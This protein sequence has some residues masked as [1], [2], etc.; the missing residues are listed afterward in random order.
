MRDCTFKLAGQ[1]TVSVPLVVKVWILSEPDVVTVPPE[2]SVVRIVFVV[3][4]Q[5]AN[6]LADDFLVPWAKKVFTLGFPGI[7]I[8]VAV[9]Q[10]AAFAQIAVPELTPERVYVSRSASG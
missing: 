6:T 4:L 8:S 5:S 2:M 7:E 3:S 10:V 1:V 9:S